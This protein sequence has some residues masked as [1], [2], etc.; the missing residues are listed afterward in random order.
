M[1]IKQDI[2]G[3]QTFIPKMCVRQTLAPIAFGQNNAGLKNKLYWIRFRLNSNKTCKD[4]LL[5]LRVLTS[6]SIVTDVT[7]LI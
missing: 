2:I 4:S 3:H 1:G 6:V 5:I 7:N